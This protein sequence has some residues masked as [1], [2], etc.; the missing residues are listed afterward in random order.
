M[1]DDLVYLRPNV[2]VEPLVDAWYAWTHLIP[3]A[4]A[5]RNLTERHIKIMDSYIAAP[6]VHAEAV[7]N[8]AMLG[9][10]FI[11]YNGKR[12]DEI[13]KLR[14]DTINRRHL[15]LELSGALAD[16]NRLITGEAK[17]LSLHPLYR[18]IAKALQ[19]KVELVYDINGTP[20]FRLIE[21][22]LYES[23]Y[24]NPDGQSLMLSEIT[25]DNRPF[26]LS[27]P[28][29][30]SPDTLHLRIPFN[31]PAV[32]RLFQMKT[33]PQK[34]SETLE[35][36]GLE[37]PL[38]ELMTRL[39]TSE[40]PPPYSSYTG[41]GVRW[42]YFGHACILVET[43]GVSILIDPVLSYTYEAGISRY[44]YE[45]LPD[46]I[47]YILI[48][49][50]HQ[51][52]VLFETLLQ[53][54]HKVGQ[55]IVPRGGGGGLQDPSLKQVLHRTG[56]K[57][58][59]ELDELETIEEGGMRIIGVP[60][61]GEHADLDIR[62]K[63]A[64]IIQT[65]RYSIMF[66]ADSCNIEPQLYENVV[67]VLGPVD[68]LFVGMECDGAPLSWLY[69]PLLLKPADRLADQSRRLSG[70]NYEQARS[71]VTALKCKEVYVYAMGLEPW[72]RHF[73]SISYTNQSRPIVDSD[74]LI[75]ECAERG[76]VAERLFGEKEI[77]TEA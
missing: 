11:D 31:D 5:A 41:K 49:H 71:L 2:Q 30:D 56:F 36:L 9:G 21:S 3:P 38:K 23:P 4:T 35:M 22:L 59:R 57:N 13:A 28:R 48:T 14:A 54:R 73:T 61:F 65:G 68:V 69:G 26:A 55:V 46:H 63:L 10:P 39:F 33:V 37:L 51:D 15:L 7:N 29:L 32:D 76:M 60:F 1:M 75:A 77:L 64:Y 66:A 72:L 47:D 42:R 24:Y 18:K 53:L 62:T 25:G 20:S 74:K 12:V 50:N 43:Q 52:H 19:G 67:K 6:D 8:P 40:P 27:T 45:D 70:S 44:T 17:G 34:L 16:L 58:V